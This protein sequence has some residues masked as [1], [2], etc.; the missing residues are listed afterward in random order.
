MGM[1]SIGGVDMKNNM[2][3]IV[4]W[5]IE[6]SIDTVVFVSNVNDRVLC[7]FTNN[8]GN[9]EVRTKITLSREGADALFR[10][11]KVAKLNRK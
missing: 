8:Q 2:K 10:C 4:G 5:E 7:I 1:I 9:A 3:K 11:L 6:T